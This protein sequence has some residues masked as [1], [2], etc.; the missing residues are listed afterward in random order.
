MHMKHAI[1][2]LV[3]AVLLAA[4]LCLGCA[5]R[6][7]VVSEVTPAPVVTPVGQD[8]DNVVFSGTEDESGVPATV[9]PQ[10]EAPQPTPKPTE[11]ANKQ[12]PAPTA[13][14]TATATATPKVTPKPTKKPSGKKTPKPTAKTTPKP[15]S[16][17][18]AT[19]T[20]SASDLRAEDLIGVWKLY[21]IM[22]DGSIMKPS[23]F[24]IEMTVEFIVNGNA[25][26]VTVTD[27]NPEE[28]AYSYTVEGDTIRLL[29]KS[30]EVTEMT[31]HADT[32]EIT[33]IMMEGSRPLELHLMRDPDAYV[34]PTPDSDSSN[35]G[36]IELPEIP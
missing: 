25:R 6:Q 31:Y 28:M 14:P 21:Q 3:S 4:G 23:D 27:G 29:S 13:N 7:E 16:T 32:D 1:P 11:A 2:V 26:S 5:G 19:A 24:S 30:E 17:A 9:P 35:D 33:L 34:T 20:P 12:T 36:D 15:S 10:T 22:Y 18:A 8:E